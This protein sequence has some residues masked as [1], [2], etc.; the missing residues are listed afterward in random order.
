MTQVSSEVPRGLSQDLNGYALYFFFNSYLF[1][2]GDPDVQ[3]GHLSCLYH[4]WT[5]RRSDSPLEPAVHAVALSLLE[6]WSFRNPNSQQ[7]LARSYYVKAIA[8]VRQHLNDGRNIDDDVLMAT[9]MLDMYDGIISFCGARGHSGL[10]IEGA[11]ALAENRLRLPIE[12]ESSQRLLLGARSH[13][14]SRAVGKREALPEEVLKW[15]LSTQDILRTPVYELEELQFALANIQAA[16]SSLTL[17]LPDKKKVAWEILKQAEKLDL[18]ITTWRAH[19]PDDWVPVTIRDMERIPTSIREAG[20]YQPHCTV[21][22]SIFTAN[23]LNARCCLHIRL[24]V[25]ILACLEYTDTLKH[26]TSRADAYENIQSMADAICASVP[27]FLGDRV[28]PQ[29]FD[30][31]S[32]RYPR[33]GDK[34]TS[35]EHYKAA[36]A[37]SGIFLTQRLS[38]LLQ[39]GLP[40]RAGQVPWVLGQMGRIKKIYLACSEATPR[41]LCK[42]GWTL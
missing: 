4:V 32:V 35:E 25:I 31:R 1:Q 9:L 18:Q 41:L 5:Q 16:A 38:E 27:F 2:L 30:D 42:G 24:Q 36:A 34:P 26:T 11:R 29:R 22:K 13:V 20:L 37:Y 7:S 33:M 23:V 8:D 3:N 15:T 6:A 39:P 12:K 28:E 14:I 21:H 40:L 19:I 10:H 17:E